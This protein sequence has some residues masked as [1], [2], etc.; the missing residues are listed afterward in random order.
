MNLFVEKQYNMAGPKA[1]R[2]LMESGG[3]KP[4]RLHRLQSARDE[5][6]TRLITMYN[7][8]DNVNNV[9]NVS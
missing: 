1:P 9:R 8:S 6:T 4:L 7:L 5:T 2:L 3:Y